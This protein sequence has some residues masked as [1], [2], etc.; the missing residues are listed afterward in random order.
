MIRRVIFAPFAI[1][2]LIAAA[3]ISSAAEPNRETAEGVL[4]EMTTLNKTMKKLNG[5]QNRL[6][7]TIVTSMRNNDLL[8]KQLAGRLEP[9]INTHNANSILFAA[10]QN[11]WR[12]LSS[13]ITGNAA[14]PWPGPRMV[15]VW[16]RKGC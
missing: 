8:N 11:D 5:E 4:R 10:N 14:V 7:A 13:G 2:A 9:L 1:A 12:I 15:D 16:S 3:Q 6:T